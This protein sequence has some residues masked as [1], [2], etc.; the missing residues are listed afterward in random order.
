MTA[1]IKPLGMAE[2]VD[3]VACIAGSIDILLDKFCG[4]A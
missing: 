2:H 1:T 3:N 4:L